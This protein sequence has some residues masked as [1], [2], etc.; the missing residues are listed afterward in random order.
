MNVC[1]P[2]KDVAEA[3]G[4]VIL[5]G[6]GLGT[7]TLIHLA[8][9]MSGR[10]LFRRWANGPG[11]QPMEVEVSGCSDGFGN[12]E[13]ILSPLGIPSAQ[14]SIS[15]QLLKSPSGSTSRAEL[16]KR[17]FKSPILPVRREIS[18]APKKTDDHGA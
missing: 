17:A 6:V 13:Q 15:S 16:L 2:P 14:A 18:R 8:E 9:R 11:G 10:N 5:M 12:L 3:N 1:A 7:M 4:S